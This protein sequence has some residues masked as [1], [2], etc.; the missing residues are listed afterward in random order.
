MALL[1]GRAEG[2]Q[3]GRV[4]RSGSRAVQ[5]YR[6]YIPNRYVEPSLCVLCGEKG[7]RQKPRGKNPGTDRLR[8]G[9]GS[10]A[11]HGQLGWNPDLLIPLSSCFPEQPATHSCCLSCYAETEEELRAICA[12][13]ASP[14]LPPSLEAPCSIWERAGQGPHKSQPFTVCG[15]MVAVP[16]AGGLPRVFTRAERRLRGPGHRHLPA[17]AHGFRGL[18]FQILPWPHSKLPQFPQRII[19]IAT[20][21]WSVH[22]NNTRGQSKSKRFLC[23]SRPAKTCTIR[24]KFDV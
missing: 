20:C 18:G 16:S 14:P 13:P 4:D 19:E 8:N 9:L 6:L 22:K 10:T 5:L 21:S 1:S 11:D 3:E 15:A 12:P 23:K 17:D 7:G 24:Y 2:S